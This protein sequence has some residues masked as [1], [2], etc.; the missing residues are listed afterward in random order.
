MSPGSW[1]TSEALPRANVPGSEWSVVNV[2]LSPAN[3]AILKLRVNVLADIDD[4]Q[5]AQ[6]TSGNANAMESPL[7][8]C[9]RS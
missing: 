6:S 8:L 3:A 4:I 5:F 2:N 1:N 7:V 9:S